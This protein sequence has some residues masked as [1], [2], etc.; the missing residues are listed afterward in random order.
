MSVKPVEEGVSARREL[1]NA[2]FLLKIYF[3][4]QD[5]VPH[6]LRDGLQHLYEGTSGLEH[7]LW[8]FNQCRFDD[9]QAENS[10]E[11]S[12]APCDGGPGACKSI[13]R[14]LR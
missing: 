4:A 5:L 13:R 1:G 6:P 7:H 11:G 3:M 12:P 14:A 9:A 2:L 10:V 8:T